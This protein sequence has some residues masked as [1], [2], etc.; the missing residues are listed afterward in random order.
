MNVLY[1]HG[2]ASSP[3]GSIKTKL[4]TETFATE[5]ITLQIPNLNVPD[6]EHLTLTAMIATTADAI[7]ACPPGTV[8]LI[9][10]S[11]GG[12]VALHTYDRHRYGAAARVAGMVLLAP[13]LDLAGNRR[14]QLGDAGVAA[15]RANST[16]TVHHYGYN[17]VRQVHFGLYED[18][19]HYHSEAVK[20]EV[21]TVIFHGTRDESVM[22]QESVAFAATHPTVDLRI[23]D[24][25]HGLADQVP[26]IF[27]ATMAL[28][29]QG[30]AS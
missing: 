11:L 26:D 8:I 18:T 3:T 1:L 6:F 20:L 12:A 24:S 13:A 19:Q 14:R 27:A 9:G 4:L 28:I 2:F 29:Q 25:D 10:S 5:G 17:E 21:P 7:A 16:I 23:V 15:W 30:N 22:F